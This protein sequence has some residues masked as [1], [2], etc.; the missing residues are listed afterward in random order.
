MKKSGFAGV[1]IAAR[2]AALHPL[3]RPF[4][5]RERGLV[6]KAASLRSPRTVDPAVRYCAWRVGTSFREDEN[7]GWIRLD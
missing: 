1:R 3:R 7:S 2:I 6:L 4:S 5:I